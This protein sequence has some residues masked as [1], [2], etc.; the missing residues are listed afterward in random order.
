MSRSRHPN[1]E[2]EK[3]LQYAEKLNWRV[4]KRTGHAWGMI[5]CPEGH[6]DH[7]MCV[8]STPKNPQNHAKQIIR[9]VNKCEPDSKGSLEEGSE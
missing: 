2:I 6:A 1:K 4:E 8:W 3:A 7:K 9:F 5:F